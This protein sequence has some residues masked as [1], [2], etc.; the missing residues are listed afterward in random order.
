LS[1]LDVRTT[2]NSLLSSGGNLDISTTGANSFTS[3]GEFNLSAGG[4]LIIGAD[5]TLSAKGA[6]IILKG[7]DIHL[8]GPDALTPTLAIEATSAQTLALYE[9][10]IVDIENEWGNKTRYRSDEYLNSIMRRIP[11]HEPWPLHEHFNPVIFSS[12]FTDR[13]RSAESEE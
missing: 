5:G 13:D 6:D 2:G 11:M 8:N 4:A 9:N 1:N 10:V 12:A 7:G 3:S